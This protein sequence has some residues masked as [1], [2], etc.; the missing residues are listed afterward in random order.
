MS[1][2]KDIQETLRLETLRRYGILDT[3]P[4][5][6]FDDLAELAAYVCQTP[7][8]VISLVG[9]DRLCL[10]AQVGLEAQEEEE[11]TRRDVSFCAYAVQESGIFIVSDA[12][13]DH[14]FAARWRSW[15]TRPGA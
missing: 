5:K 15:I 8:A 7:V 2:L 4:E 1:A 6:V 9:A 10:K 11:E 3:K 12:L 13:E 14:R